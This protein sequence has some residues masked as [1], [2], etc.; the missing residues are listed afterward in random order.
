LM[1]II[2]GLLVVSFVRGNKKEEEQVKDEWD[3]KIKNKN[4]NFNIDA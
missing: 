2:A 4:Q 1:A 3:S